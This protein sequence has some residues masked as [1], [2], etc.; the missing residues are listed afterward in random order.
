MKKKVLTFVL[1]ACGHCDDRMLNVLVLVHLRFVQRV[2]KVRR[3]VVFVADSDTNVFCHCFDFQINFETIET[4]SLTRI[5]TKLEKN[6]QI[7]SAM[8]SHIKLKVK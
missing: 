1:V 6:K 2:L 3:I 8:C 4:I 5:R 7:D